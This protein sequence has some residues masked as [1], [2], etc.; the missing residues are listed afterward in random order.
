M[1]NK[2]LIF[3]NLFILLAISVILSGCSKSAGKGYSNVTGW[4]YNDKTTT[5]FTVKDEVKG[6]VPHGMLPVEGGTFTIGEKTEAVTA[7]RNNPRRRITISSFYMDQYEITNLNWREYVYWM[8]LV[9]E[10]AAPE[11]VSKARPDKNVWREE[12]AYNDPL[13]QYYFDHPNFNYYPIVGVSWEQAMDYCQWRTDRLNEDALIKAGFIKSPDF[14]AIEGMDLLDITENFVFSTQKYLYSS[15][16]Y[17]AEGKKQNKDL[18]GNNKKASMAEGVLYPD[19][20]LPTEAEWEFAAYGIKVS[21]KNKRQGFVQETREYPWSGMQMRNPKKGKYRGMMLA[22]YVR[23][24]GDMMGTSGALDDRG[25]TTV[26]VNSYFPN[27]FGLFNMAG[28][29]NEW[30]LDVYRSTSFEDE[31]EYNSFR[32]NVYTMFESDGEDENGSPLFVIDSLGRIKQVVAKDGDKR[33][34]KDGDV[35]SRVMTDFLL[36]GDTAGLAEMQRADLKIDPTDVLAPQIDDE[37]RVYKGGSWKD[38]VYWLSSGSRRF[39]N[40][41]KRTNDI[42][43]RCAMSMIGETEKP[44]K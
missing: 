4:K 27:D 40:Q 24:R 12:L 5:G 42:G 7:A 37:T 25:V 19:V 43:F 11:I 14:K 36:A 35:M 33:S 18:Y 21:K 29:V 23:G 38:R 39:L 2:S 8:Q 22:N 3:K 20:R 9:F 31:S 16:Y 6:K 28:N 13:I 15:T 41:K 1:V 34:F 10:Q 44:I 30:V 26:P 17:P 32:G